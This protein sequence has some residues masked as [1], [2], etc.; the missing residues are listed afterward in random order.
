MPAALP[1][2]IL[3]YVHGTNC[4][5]CMGTLKNCLSSV[6]SIIIKQEH[7]KRNIC[8]L[9]HY[10]FTTMTQPIN[11]VSVRTHSKEN[12]RIE[13]HLQNNSWKAVHVFGFCHFFFLGGGAA[14]ACLVGLGVF[15]KKISV[16]QKVFYSARVSQEGGMRGQKLFC[17]CL[18]R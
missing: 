15:Y 6:I 14:N 13:W 10:K 2:P 4:T 11:N 17:Q 9:C 3:N 5:K 7:F 12:T 1:A 18:N 16:Q 8:A